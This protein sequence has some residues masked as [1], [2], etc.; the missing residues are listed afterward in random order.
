MACDVTS[1]GIILE[2]MRATY[3]KKNTVCISPV[4]PIVESSYFTISTPLVKYLFWMNDGAGADP[5]IAGYTSVEVDTSAA[6]DIASVAALLKTAMEAVEF[7]ATISTDTLSLKVECKKLGLVLEVAADVDTTFVLA[8]DVVGTG[9]FLGLTEPIEMT[10]ETETVDITANQTGNTVLDKFITAV[11]ASISTTLLQMTKENWSL[12]VGQ[13]VGGNYTPAGGTELTGYGS[14]SINKSFFAIAGELNLQ[15]IAA[16]EN[17]HSRDLTFHSTV[18]NPE[19][20]NFDS[21]EKQGMAVT[22]EALLDS[23]KNKNINLFSFGDATLDLR[24]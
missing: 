8:T 13:G 22:F 1:S 17:D 3:G 4:F 20:I 21:L 19:S 5:V 9:G 2:G 10:M 7:W 23:S 15:P 12:L 11:A 14:A 18:V 16:D 6:T 24:K